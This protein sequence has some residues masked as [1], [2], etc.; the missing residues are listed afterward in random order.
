M[1]SKGRKKFKSG[2][3]TLPSLQYTT[4]GFGVKDRR[5]VLAGGLSIPVVWSRELPCTPSSVRVFQDALGHWYASFVVKPDDGPLPATGRAVG[6]DWGVKRIATADNPEYDLAHPEH[7]TKAATK[8][9]RY[10]RMMA[11]RKPRPAQRASRGYRHAKNRTAKLRKK[12]ARQR[13]DTARKWVRKIVKAH[14]RLAVENF[15]PA[16]LTQSRMARKAADAAI[17]ATKTELVDYA[18]RMGR[19]IV[20]V[21]PKYTTMD[22]SN[23]DARAKH[24]L[25]LSQRTFVCENCEFVADRDRNAAL[26]MRNRAG[27]QPAAVDAVRLASTEP[28]TAQRA[29]AS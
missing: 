14:D 13:Q 26:V 16:F 22:C 25:P 1:K 2:K 17:G 12:V 21:N 7:G 4:R 19:V 24:R 5:L 20:L 29:Q 18:T 23:C 8:L 15:K 28:A 3:K 10:Q 9:A 27:F 6:V 11:R